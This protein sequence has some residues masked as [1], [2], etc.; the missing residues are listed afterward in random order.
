MDRNRIKMPKV[1]VLLPNY[2]NAPYLKEAIDSILNQTFTDFEFIIVDDGSTDNSIEIINSYDDLR[3]I[4]ILKEENSGIVD[5]LNRGLENAKGEYLVR[6]DG[7]D[8]SFPDRIEKLVYFL[9][10][11]PEI[12]VCSSSLKNVGLIDEIWTD[13]SDPSI[14]KA[15]VLF[16]NPLG[17]PTSVFRLNML[18]ENNIRYKNGYPFIEDYK[19]FS[20]LNSITLFSSVPDVLYQYRRLPHTSTI[21]NSDTLQERIKLVHVEVL[22][23]LLGRIPTNVELK[24]HFDFYKGVYRLRLQEYKKWAIE[25]ISANKQNPI[26]PS[27]ELMQVIDQRMEKLKYKSLDISST[28]IWDIFKIDSAIKLK[29]IKYLLGNLRHRNEK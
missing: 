25:L 1:S 9:D 26:Y 7:D 8:I 17:H 23:Q 12:G 27:K 6:M 5:T 15:K 14:N 3:I 13:D 4:L 11:N 2:N 29:Y 24:I 20:D 10:E 18:K 19:L 16:G 21:A 28:N 22:N